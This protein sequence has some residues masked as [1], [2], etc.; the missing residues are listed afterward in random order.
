MRKILLTIS[1]SIYFVVSSFAQQNYAQEL[2]NLMQQGRYSDAKELC[3]NHAAQ[4]PSNDRALE[5]L[6]KSH[7]SLFLNKPDS[8]AIYMEDL[9]ANHEMI[10]GPVVGVYYGRL[11]QVYD[12]TQRFKDGVLLCDKYLNYMKRNPFDLNQDFV[13]NETNWID[14]VKSAL[15]DRGLSEPL[16]KI[17]RTNHENNAIK[18][19]DGEY[20]RFNAQYNDIPLQTFFDTGVTEYFFITKNLADKIGV[21]IIDTKQDSI[22]RLN[23]I[24]TKAM[25]GVIDKIEL[26]NLKLSNIPVLVF[27]DPFYSHLPDTLSN[28]ERAK[29]EDVFSENQ[30][31]MGLPAMLLIGKFEFDWVKR[32]LSFPEDTEKVKTNTSPNMYLTGRYPYALLKINGLSYTG[33]LDTGDNDFLSM[34]FPFYERNNSSIQL[35]LVTPKKPLTYHGMNRSNFNLPYELV[36]DPWIYSNG[37][38]INPDVNKVVIVNKMRNFNTYDGTVGVRFLY[39]MGPKVILDFKNMRIEGKFE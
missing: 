39:R 3:I 31:I 12:D 24:P 4:L 7:M 16:I 22:K 17:A 32:T 23:G 19:N 33:Y 14:S 2:V 21:K 5:V 18:L 26:G 28:T 38:Q 34:E 6:Y 30:L 13:R 10:M 27:Y 25:K 35:D 1:L 36:K 15:K 29:V 37:M 20:I 9:L 11:L 8:A